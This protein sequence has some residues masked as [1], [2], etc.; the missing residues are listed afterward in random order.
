MHDYVVAVLEGDRSL[1]RSH[2][3]EAFAARCGPEAFEGLVERSLER[4]ATGRV[5]RRLDVVSA[6]TLSDGRVSVRVR[7][8]S[9]EVRPPF[10]VG[11]WSSDHTF[12]LVADGGVWRIDSLDWPAVCR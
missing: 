2:F 4:T 11:S 12:V 7:V 6:A 1:A 8:T 5:D 3:S 9:T 10:G